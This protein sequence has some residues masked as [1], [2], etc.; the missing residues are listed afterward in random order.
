M[1]NNLGDIFGSLAALGYL[2]GSPDFAKEQIKLFQF[3]HGETC[4]FDEE[5]LFIATSS[6]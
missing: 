2:Y 6:H 5:F 3:A 4:D 1:N